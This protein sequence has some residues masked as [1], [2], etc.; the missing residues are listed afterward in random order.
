M[1]R[2]RSRT[3]ENSNYT[4][5]KDGRQPQAWCFR[6]SGCAWW[7][8]TCTC[9]VECHTFSHCCR[10]NCKNISKIFLSLTIFL[11]QKICMMGFP[12]TTAAN[13]RIIS[14]R[15]HFV[16]P[17]HH[18][19]IF[20]IVQCQFFVQRKPTRLTN[21]TLVQRTNVCQ[22]LDV[23]WRF[24]A[25]VCACH[26]LFHAHVALLFSFKHILAPLRQ[27][28]DVDCRLVALVALLIEWYMG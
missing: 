28:S 8:S 25:A 9:D 5:Q 22:A 14:F 7:C 11:V 3:N 13:V 23:H 10:F 1:W 27:C 6:G 16:H 26:A 12:S 2:K 19:D 18:C 4:L 21:G 15:L 17:V 20:R 24:T